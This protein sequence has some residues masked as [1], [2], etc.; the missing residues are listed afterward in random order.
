[1]AKAE[2]FEGKSLRQRLTTSYMREGA[3]VPVERGNQRS[4]VASLG[5]CLEVLNHGGVFCIYPEG[6]RSPDGRLYRAKTGVAWLALM[7]GVPVVPVAMFGTD[8]VLPPG[9]WLPRPAAVRIVFGSPLDPAVLR[10]SPDD[11]RDRR[12]V[13]DVIIA[14]IG[15]VSGQEYVPCFASAVKQARDGS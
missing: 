13:S 4:A 11:A 7:S 12:A 2:Y 15:S 9:K 10:G 6:T 8:R 3:Q 14:A 5:A 1:M